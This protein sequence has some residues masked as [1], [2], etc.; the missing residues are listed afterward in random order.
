MTDTVIARFLV[1]LAAVLVICAGF[2]CGSPKV[3]Q[4]PVEEL[5]VIDEPTSG[6]EP[7][8]PELPADEEP[9]TDELTSG[10]E[11]DPPDH[12]ADEEPDTDV[13]T[14]GSEPDLPDHRAEE[15]PH[16]DITSAGGREPSNGGLPGGEETGNG[17]SRGGEETGNGGSGDSHDIDSSTTSERL[18]QELIDA[19]AA[20]DSGRIAIAFPDT[21]Q[22][23]VKQ[24]IEV[25][26]TLDS[27]V[28]LTAGFHGRPIVEKIK[29][30]QRMTARLKF[31]T[32]DFNMSLSDS[33]LVTVTYGGFES[34][35]WEVTPQ[36]SG[37]K[38]FRLNVEVLLALA[39]G[40]DAP[41]SAFKR[42]FVAA[43]DP[44]Y[45]WVFSTFIDTHWKLLLKSGGGGALA[46]I[47]VWVYRRF[48]KKKTRRPAGF[49]RG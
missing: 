35:L 5:P 20:V 42:N 38:V 32:S 28:D 21:M 48:R 37:E 13:P 41:K 15:E 40:K 36:K 7:D 16:T 49:E 27:N 18:G 25:R 26:V 12:A 2:G 3:G 29:V 19:F 14:N 45:Y 30:G 8:L 24:T 43:V 34:W 4:P 44:D 47:G 9:D 22:Q 23:G 31:D 10:L 39:N 1:V 6:V 17:G 33:P 11:P 46:S